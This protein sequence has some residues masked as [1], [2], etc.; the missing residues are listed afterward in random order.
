LTEERD[1]LAVRKS[2][3]DGSWFGVALADGKATSFSVWGTGPE[4]DRGPGSRTDDVDAGCVERSD[5]SDASKRSARTWCRREG[6]CVVEAWTSSS[7]S[8]S[9]A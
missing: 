4:I 1:G 2:D 8:R 5:R 3:A 7:S 6:R 9:I